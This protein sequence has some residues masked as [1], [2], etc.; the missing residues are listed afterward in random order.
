MVRGARRIVSGILTI[1]RTDGSPIEP[2]LAAALMSPLAVRGP[3]AQRSQCIGNVALGH[4]LLR[5]RTE[6][7]DR[8][9][10]TLDG[11]TWIVADVRLD[12]R[13]DLITQ[14]GLNRDSMSL[15]SDAELVL[16]AY[17]EWDVGCIN[18]LLGDFGFAIWDAR[19]SRLFVGRDHLGVKP[20]YYAHVGRSI[21]VSSVLECVRMHPAVRKDE[22]E[23]IAIA[24]FL[25][26]GH[27]ADHETTVYRDI[28]RLP[29]AHTLTWSPNG[30]RVQRYWQLPVEEPIYCSDAEYAEQFTDLLGR[31]VSDRL[32]TDRVSIF[33]SGGIDSTTLAATAVRELGDA[34]AVRGFTFVRGSLID[35]EGHYARI[36]ARE[37]GIAAR[38]YDIDQN[39]GWPHFMTTAIP[40]PLPDAVEAGAKAR[41]HADMAMH[42]AVAL[43]GEGPDNVM[44]YEW[45]AYIRHLW[46]GHRWRQLSADFMRFVGHHKRLPLAATLWR[47][48][49]RSTDDR[50]MPQLPRWIAPSL[51]DRLQLRERWQRVMRGPRPS[52]HPTKPMAYWSLLNPMWHVVF[53]AV[54]PAYTG[55]PIDVRH[56]YLDLR[57]LRFL[58]RVPAIP[59]SRDKHL[60]RYALSDRLPATIRTRP[61]TP[62]KGLPDYER[63]R[64]FGLPPLRASE[65]LERY[66]SSVRLLDTG[67]R[68][69]AEAEADLRFI[70]LS[71]WLEQ[72]RTGV[73]LR[74]PATITSH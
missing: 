21:L 67:F 37:L 27:K 47:L 18:Q 49:A 45:Q 66:G 5:T 54:D 17:Q 60:F 62:L 4:A 34:E 16:R 20:L 48:G 51:V 8:Q 6:E 55:V 29:P 26:F 35:D 32:R 28:R 15:A 52:P 11:H 41:A 38:C 69:A 24:D 7:D 65:E 43:F 25:L 30:M 53:D 33:L 44:H 3:D 39:A 71:Y 72:R 40:E 10:L 50:D 63:S 2:T 74:A 61:K 64:R 14:L 36:A 22:L 70:A 13:A 56:P 19:L 57:L 59:W 73:G 46:R 1:V 31:A 23:D 12:A 58:L 42:G 9:P 68:T